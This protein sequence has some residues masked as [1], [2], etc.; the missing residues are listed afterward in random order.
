MI[1][2]L[3]N[4]SESDIPFKRFQFP[5]GQPHCEF[6]PNALREAAQK[7]PIDVVAA[8]KSGDDLL[9]V[10]LAIEAIDS[11][12]KEAKL[13]F[14]LTL[15]ISYLLGARMDR[16]IA[17]GQPASLAVVASLLNASL[18]ASV[19]SGVRVLDPHSPV[20]LSALSQAEALYPDALV[21]FALLH[22]KRD[23]G[24]TPVVVIP[25]AGAVARTNGILSR[26]K[27]DNR[28]ARCSKKRDSQTGKLSGFQLDEGDVSG[29]VALIV[30]DICDGGGTFAG[31]AK[32]LREHGAAKVYLCVTHG[33][34]SKGI[35]IDGINGVFSTDSYYM[36][37]QAGYEVSHDIGDKSVLMIKRE[38]RVL[39]TI[40]TRF[41]SQILNSKR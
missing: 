40:M 1:I 24:Q 5:D 28:I 30:D 6:D 8:I 15:N 7:E 38:G 27:A 10:A 41:M 19:F 20:T 23:E 32:V 21:A 37:D 29:R 35:E 4:P 39:L 18:R 33:I 16:R 11:A 9:N 36:S 34:F 3:D 25:D 17:A 14:P 12:L 13:F 31:I 22:I 26:L 2:H